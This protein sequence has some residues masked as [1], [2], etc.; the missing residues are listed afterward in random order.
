MVSWYNNRQAILGV[1]SLSLSIVAYAATAAFFYYGFNLVTS[2]FDLELPDW[3]NL[4]FAGGMV[5][6]VT[7]VGLIRQRQGVGYIGYDQIDPFAGKELGGGAAYHM[8]YETMRFTGPA[9]VILQIALAGPFQFCGAVSRFRSILP[10]DPGLERDL[11][12]LLEDVRRIDR[13]QDLSDYD[14]RSE[15]MTILIRMGKVDFSPRKG[16]LRAAAS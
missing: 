6:L 14:D 12:E 5:V 11:T 16:R 10:G 15:E 4:A 7:I 8:A 3:S 13:W 1:L 9:F 2:A